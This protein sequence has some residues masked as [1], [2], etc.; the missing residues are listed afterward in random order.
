MQRNLNDTLS[1][2]LQPFNVIHDLSTRSE[3][4]TACIPTHC[5]NLKM[6]KKNTVQKTIVIFLLTEQL[7][8]L[9]FKVVRQGQY[10]SSNMSRRSF[11][12]N[13]NLPQKHE[14][15]KLN[16]SQTHSHF[17]PLYTWCRFKL[18]CMDIGTIACHQSH[19]IPCT[20]ACCK[21]THLKGFNMFLQHLMT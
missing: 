14:V 13:I 6:V 21:L 9:Y 12:S 7:Q 18:M 19:V 17:C 20:S 10:Q 1:Y 2:S 8:N 15:A 5:S 3:Y 4:E 16:I 11:S